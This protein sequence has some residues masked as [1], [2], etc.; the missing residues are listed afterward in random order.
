MESSAKTKGTCLLKSKTIKGQKA[1]TPNLGLAK[2]P[3]TLHA[4]T[5]SKASGPGK[6]KVT[7]M[8]AGIHNGKS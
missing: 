4:K 1:T 3:T 2:Q 8:K 6:L 7:P 5:R